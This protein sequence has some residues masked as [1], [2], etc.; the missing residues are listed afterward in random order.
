MNILSSIVI[1]VFGGLFPI[2]LLYTPVTYMLCVF[3]LLTRGHTYVA[4]AIQ[5]MCSSFSW[6][7]LPCWGKAAAFLMGQDVSRFTLEYITASYRKGYVVFFVQCYDILYYATI[8][9]AIATII[10]L[11]IVWFLRIKVFMR[12]TQKM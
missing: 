12:S 10:A 3:A 6:S 7:L 9:W 1:G 8:G 11:L 2:P 5:F 4:F